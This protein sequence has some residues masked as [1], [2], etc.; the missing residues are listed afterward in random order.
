[1]N[2]SGYCALLGAAMLAGCTQATPEQQIVNDAATALGG[3]D[4]IVAVK[5]IVM[6]GEG[7]Q[8]NP[9]QDVTPEATGQTF[10]VTA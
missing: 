6:E 5:T 10:T 9:G 7:T 3:R 4:R 2:R 1:M 8:Y